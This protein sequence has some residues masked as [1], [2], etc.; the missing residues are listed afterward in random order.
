MS[1]LNKGKLDLQKNVK[2]RELLEKEHRVRK[3]IITA[4]HPV[5]EGT[6]NPVSNHF[7]NQNIDEL[8]L[9]RKFHNSVS[10]GTLYICTCCDQLW[11]KHSVSPAD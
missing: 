1:P 2:E 8:A 4:S 6:S 5:G 7:P 9:V 10:A 3:K 11:Y